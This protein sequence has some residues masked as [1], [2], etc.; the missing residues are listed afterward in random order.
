[1][2]DKCLIFLT[3]C[4]NPNGMSF[5]KL[6]DVYF[7]K[8]QYI[9]AIKFYL[10][11]TD[12]RILF[13]ENSNNDISEFFKEEIL[14]GRIE[15]LT[16]KGNDFDKSFGKGYGEMLIFEFAF[17]NSIFFQQ[18]DLILKVTG[19]H[20]LA[21]INRFIKFLTFN[22]QCELLVDLTKSMRW[23]DSRFFCFS[24]FFFH[25][26]LRNYKKQINDSHF[27]H[28]EHALAKASLEAIN[29]NVNYF[30]FPSYPKY[31]GVAGTD[32]NKIR[33]NFLY[34]LPRFIKYILKYKIILR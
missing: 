20:K 25:K 3:G 4:I 26:Y 31:I 23:A 30:P 27:F 29:D 24:K 11:N 34:L 2:N 5:T 33:T 18:S 16:F 13:V 28:F 19:R 1:M 21:N 22:S 7:R 15:I 17:E 9:S 14:E 32:G 10:A 12:L 8:Q 6:N